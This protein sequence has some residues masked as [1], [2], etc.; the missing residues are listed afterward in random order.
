MA[1]PSA[2]PL[3]GGGG[4][5]VISQ[6]VNEYDAS[7]SSTSSTSFVD[8]TNA[9]ASITPANVNNKILVIMSWSV[10]VPAAGS[11]TVIDN[12][13]LRDATQISGPLR[14]S[15]GAVSGGVATEVQ[16]GFTFLDDP[17]TTSEVTYKLQQQRGGGSV[18]VTSFN[19]SIT[20][21]EVSA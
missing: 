15:A 13:V 4:D 1:T 11:N 12:I 16:S 5:G 10:S 8:V 7:G 19:V 2:F 3:S 17:A 21:Q 18:N 9:E 6:L 20:L 14:S